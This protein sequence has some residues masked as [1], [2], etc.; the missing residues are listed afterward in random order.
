MEEKLN[1]IENKITESEKDEKLKKK[2]FYCITISFLT[3]IGILLFYYIFFLIS[4]S[5]DKSSKNENENEE[6][7]KEKEN[8]LEYDDDKKKCISCKPGYKLIDGKCKE[9]FSFR[10]LYETEK[11]DETIELIY[12]TLIDKIINVNIDGKD[13]IPSRNYTLKYAGSHIVYMLLNISNTNDLKSMFYQISALKSIYFSKNFDTKNIKY[14][15]GMFFYCKKLSDVN[16]SN[17]DTRNVVYMNELFLGC[18]SL[19]SVDISNFNVNN[20]VYIYSLF[21]YCSSLR[22]V[23]L[24]NFNSGKITH[25]NSLFQGCSSL[26]SVDLSKFNTEKVISISNLFNG[27]ESLTSVDLSNFETGKVQF[28]I[29]IFNNCTNLKYIDISKFTNT[30]TMSYSNFCSN[31]PQIG[32]IKAKKDFY[33]NIKEFIPESWVK[34]LI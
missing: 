3:I 29:N 28:M 20:A 7:E 25:M 15:S 4:F 24:P 23:K 8:C 19:T 1:D 10:A 6:K 9:N 14:M 30:S 33:E 27:C 21:Q 13:V 32:T 2:L 31:L 11:N 12:I 5:P 17:F 16:L 26:T 18:F 22:Y 34:N